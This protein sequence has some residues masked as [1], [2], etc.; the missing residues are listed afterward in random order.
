MSSAISATGNAGLISGIGKLLIVETSKGGI[1]TVRRSVL[2]RS[3]V[4]ASVLTGKN[5]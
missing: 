3:Q 1:L 4:K 2:A 5:I